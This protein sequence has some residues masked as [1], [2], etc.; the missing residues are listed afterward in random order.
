MLINLLLTACC[1]IIKMTVLLNFTCCLAVFIAKSKFCLAVFCSD[2]TVG[3]IKLLYD[4]RL[5]R[6]FK[7]I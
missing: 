6:A 7:F 1:M 2:G 4:L 3:R 5:L